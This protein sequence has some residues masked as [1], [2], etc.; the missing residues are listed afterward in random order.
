MLEEIFKYDR[1]EIGKWMK[2][3]LKSI[4]CQWKQWLWLYSRSWCTMKCQVSTQGHILILLSNPDEDIF[5]EL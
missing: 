1:E 3:N 2:K 5:C 4:Y